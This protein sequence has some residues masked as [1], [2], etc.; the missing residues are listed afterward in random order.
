MRISLQEIH[1]PLCRDARREPLLPSYKFDDE[2]D[3]F[4][5]HPEIK[6]VL[7]TNCG[8]VYENP[9]VDMALSEDY[10]DKHYYW[11]PEQLDRMVRHQTYVGEQ[12]W[13]MLE[14]RLDWQSVNRTLDIGATAAWS[15]ILKRALPQAETVVVE[16]S[17]MATELSRR[18]YPEVTSICRTF[19]AF[20]DRPGSYDFI[21]LWY[22]I[23]CISDARAALAKARRLLS[24]GG[25]LLISISHLRMGVEIWQCGMPWVNLAQVVN[26]VSLVYYSRRTLARFLEA[27]GF[28]LVEAFVTDHADGDEGD[29]DFT[30][31]QDYVVIAELAERKPRP[32][33]VDDLSDPDE[34]AQSREFFSNYVE[35]ASM[36]SVDALLSTRET[37]GVSVLHN[38]DAVFGAFAAALFQRHGLPV[39]QYDI[40]DGRN[41]QLATG[42]EPGH[43]VLNLTNGN[44]GVAEM[45]AQAKHFEAFDCIQSDRS[46][47]FGNWIMGLD[48]TPIMAKAI[49]PANGRDDRLFPFAQ[50]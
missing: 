14:P 50:A 21:S 5:L 43:I 4:C 16:P 19:E 42:D 20:D 35:R 37:K 11:T 13:Q 29:N 41:I 8:L 36:A 34:V 7:C 1:C 25:R 15:A 30:G 49:C 17:S 46:D 48:G 23:Y 40:G 24:D 6:V 45:N 33:S 10:S 26:G 38:G 27:E 3:R 12:R 9:G 22:S 31:R 47:V 28:R 39:D 44:I 2:V 32:V 18:Q